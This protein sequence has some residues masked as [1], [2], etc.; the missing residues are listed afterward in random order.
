MKTIDVVRRIKGFKFSEEEVSM[1]FRGPVRCYRMD[2]TLDDRN[3]NEVV[4][5][6]YREMGTDWREGIQGL[7]EG[8]LQEAKDYA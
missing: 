5:T 8:V 3:G 6:H 1:Y 7:L 2:M 4:L